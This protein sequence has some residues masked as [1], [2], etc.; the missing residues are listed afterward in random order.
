MLVRGRDACA[1]HAFPQRIADAFPHDRKALLTLEAC[2]TAQYPFSADQPIQ[3]ADWQMY[4]SQI[5]QEVMAEQSPKRL[6]QVR[7]RLYELLINCIPP[8]LI[9][10]TLTFEL[11]RKLDAEV[12]HEVMYWAAFYEHRLQMGQKPIFHLEAFVARFMSVYKKFL[13]ATFG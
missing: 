13:L 5:A 12:K 7:N 2:R 8:E 10:K 9:L 1:V 3:Q 6:F 4:V 11:L